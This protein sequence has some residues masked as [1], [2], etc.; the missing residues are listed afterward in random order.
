M[1]IARKLT[2][3]VELS[4]AAL[5]ELGNDAAARNRMCLMAANTFGSVRAGVTASS[6]GGRYG[7]ASMAIEE[8][9]VPAEDAA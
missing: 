5:R 6:S 1:I 4:D 7:N 9:R 2:I 8:R 3:V